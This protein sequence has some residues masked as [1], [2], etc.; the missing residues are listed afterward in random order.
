[1]LYIL[2]NSGSFDNPPLEDGLTRR[3]SLTLLVHVETAL[4]QLFISR[5]DYKDNHDVAGT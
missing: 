2:Q 4:L 5:H 1:M 3:W